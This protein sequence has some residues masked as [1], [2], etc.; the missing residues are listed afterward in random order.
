MARAFIPTGVIIK[1]QLVV[2]LG[3]P[4][5]A[6]RQ[7]LGDDRVLPPLLVGLLGDFLGDA[8]LLVR[9]VEDAAA[10]LR[11]G[12]RA[13]AVRGRGVVHFVEVGD[14]GGVGEFG[15]VEDDLAGFGVY[16]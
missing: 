8:L 16:T 4:P 5:L 3:I 2:L 9:V 12:V 1:I 11:A 10:V 15:G 14:D 6:R 7:D 13:L